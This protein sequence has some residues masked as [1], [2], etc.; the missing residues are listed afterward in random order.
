MTGNKLDIVTQGPEAFL[1]GM[2]QGIV[3]TP[4]KIGAADRSPEQHIADD[5][6]PVAGLEK[7]DMAGRMAGAMMY[8]QGNITKTDRIAFVQPAVRDERLRT[9]KSEFPAR[10]IE[11]VEPETV[12]GMR[13]FNRYLEPPGKFRHASRMIDMP[14]GHQYFLY[15]ETRLRSD[16]RDPIHLASRVNNRSRAALL[17][18]KQ[19]T[20]LLKWGNG[21]HL[22]FHDGGLCIRGFSSI[23]DGL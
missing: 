21:N 22:Y 10:R 18:A 9:G 17:A 7:D 13:S 12:I 16:R 19:G 1:N 2:D 6:E 20:I 11:T 14:M 3:I 23:S 15:P 5:G 8:I 4:R